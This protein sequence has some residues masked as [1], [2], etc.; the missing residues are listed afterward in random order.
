MVARVFVCS[1]CE[2]D[3]A[4]VSLADSAAVQRA[5]AAQAVRPVPAYLRALMMRSE[6]AR[7]GRI[8]GEIFI[9]WRSYALGDLKVELFRLHRCRICRVEG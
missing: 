1:A 6:V 2:I 4:A 9:G 3:R 8:D 5:A 7:V